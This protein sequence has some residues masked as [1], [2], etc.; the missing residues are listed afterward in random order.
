MDEKK[1]R[2]VVCVL[3]GGVVESVFFFLF[4]LK[5]LDTLNDDET[6][7]MKGATIN[8]PY[9]FLLFPLLHS[10]KVTERVMAP[11]ISLGMFFCGDR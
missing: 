8:E 4:F 2:L 10:R 1:R 3:N 9:G 11:C 6:L 5:I 7:A